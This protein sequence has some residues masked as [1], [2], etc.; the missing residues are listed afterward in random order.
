MG[1]ME[2][3]KQIDEVR[4]E[5]PKDFKQGMRVPARIY[6]D[7]EL[8]NEMQKDLTL[9]QAVN[10]SFLQGIYNYSITL[11]DGHQGYG[12][13]IGGVAATDAETGVISPGGV[14]Y[15]INCG[16]RLLRTNLEKRCRAEDSSSGGNSLS[17]RAIGV[18]EH[19]PRQAHVVSA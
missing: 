10:V 5:I 17:K 14:G 13:P 2:K 11:P 18:G 4:W 3:V 8:F 1:L 6:A 7:A 19:W 12:F 16:V 15:D 9:E